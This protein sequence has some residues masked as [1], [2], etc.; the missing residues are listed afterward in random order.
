MVKPKPNQKVIQ[1]LMSKNEQTLFLSVITIGEL[2]KGINKLSESK[3]KE[4]IK[5]WV[6]N[7]L[8]Q[9]FDKK[10][11]EITEEIAKVWGEIQGKTEKEGKK[12]PAIDSLLGATAIFYDMIM[13][14]RNPFNTELKELSILN[15]WE[16]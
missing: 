5:L 1:W 11:L 8:R 14:T 3:K 7:D 9:R 13:V 6:T 16:L 10:I 2:W 4:E 12:L 15:P